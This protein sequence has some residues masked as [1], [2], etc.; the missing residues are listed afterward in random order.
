MRGESKS[1]VRFG[2]LQIYA[3]FRK[4]KT[5]FPIEVAVMWGKNTT[6]MKSEI[7]QEDHY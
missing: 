6:R 7:T 4:L 1:E 2:K 3:Q 5:G